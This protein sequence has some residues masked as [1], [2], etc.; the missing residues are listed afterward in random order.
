M[1]AALPTWS[2]E[3]VQ[4]LR[5]ADD[6]RYAAMMANDTWALERFLSDHLAYTHSDG[7]TDTKSQYLAQI[8]EG[9]LRYR[10]HVREKLSCLPLGEQALVR[11]V[12]RLEALFNGSETRIRIHYLAAWTRS[13]GS[14]Q[15]VGWASTRLPEVSQ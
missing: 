7:Q 13:E 5:A 1:Q 15:L 11:G 3:L 14:W 9:R 8:A 6:A 10:R 4:D 2:P 12:L